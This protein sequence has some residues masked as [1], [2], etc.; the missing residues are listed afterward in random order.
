MIG[1]QI[2]RCL[3]GGVLFVH[4]GSYRLSASCSRDICPVAA[5]GLGGEGQEAATVLRADIDLN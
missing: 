5:K 4:P 2:P 3:E 1:A